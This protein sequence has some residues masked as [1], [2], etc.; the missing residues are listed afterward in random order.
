[1]KIH[2]VYLKQIECPLQTPCHM[3]MSRAVFSWRSVWYSLQCSGLCL[4]LCLQYTTFSIPRDI[5]CIFWQGIQ[6][7]KNLRDGSFCEERVGF[8]NSE[9]SKQQ[10]RR[11]WNS[12]ET[13]SRDTCSFGWVN[14]WLHRLEI[15]LTLEVKTR[16]YHNVVLLQNAPRSIIRWNTLFQRSECSIIVEFRQL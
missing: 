14:R 6:I 10:L 1:M 16:Q 4:A 15:T 5:V 3:V 2:T 11:S 12:E 7:F 8:K 9:G 13:T